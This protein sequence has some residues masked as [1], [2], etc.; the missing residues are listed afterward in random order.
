ME[1]HGKCSA[2]TAGCLGFK[3]DRRLVAVSTALPMPVD[4]VSVVWPHLNNA[5]SEWSLREELYDALKNDEVLG[6]REMIIPW[7]TETQEHVQT[8]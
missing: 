4:L 8:S 1:T 3:M 6:Y 2:A 7:L 5:C